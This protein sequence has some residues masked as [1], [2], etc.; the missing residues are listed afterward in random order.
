MYR[1]TPFVCNTNYSSSVTIYILLDILLLIVS[2]F[3]FAGIR[4]VEIIAI[5]SYKN[6]EQAFKRGYKLLDD[7]TTTTQAMGYYHEITCKEL[8]EKKKKGRANYRKPSSRETKIRSRTWQSRRVNRE[9]QATEI[10]L[11]KTTK[12]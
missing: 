8:T 1:P 5:M 12:Y 2:L 9:A 6:F 4:F 3:Y 7:I 11:E 10:G